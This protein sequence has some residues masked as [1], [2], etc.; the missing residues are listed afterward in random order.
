M[1]TDQTSN[2]F[3]YEGITFDHQRQSTY[4]ETLIRYANKLFRLITHIDRSYDFQTYGRLEYFNGTD[5]VKI[6][7]FSHDQIAQIMY[8]NNHAR[9]TGYRDDIF[10]EMVEGIISKY[11]KFMPHEELK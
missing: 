9:A 6:S 5:F 1:K 7:T 2:G 8:H 11:E 4:E 3:S 10:L